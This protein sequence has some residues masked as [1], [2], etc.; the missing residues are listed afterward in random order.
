M[1]VCKTSKMTNKLESSGQC[2]EILHESVQVSHSL[3]LYSNVIALQHK[4]N[5]HQNINNVSRN[6]GS[7][8]QVS[9]LSC[10]TV[11]WALHPILSSNLSNAKSIPILKLSLSLS[12]SI[13]NQ[14]CCLLIKWLVAIRCKFLWDNISGFRVSILWIS[15]QH[16]CETND[17]VWCI[18]EQMWEYWW[19]GILKSVAHVEWCYV[20]TVPN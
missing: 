6:C 1:L 14:A 19:R 12:L 15:Y 2:G 17:H 4:C 20:S 9:A 18:C 8:V 3:S 5:H 13:Q 16:Q 7:T 11:L 10:T